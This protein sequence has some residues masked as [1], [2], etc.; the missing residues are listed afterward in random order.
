MLAMKCLPRNDVQLSVY[1]VGDGHLY[2][3]FHYS[4]KV[5][6]GPPSVEPQLIANE[7]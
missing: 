7:Q 4:D 1:V 5:G 6:N 3:D 2:C